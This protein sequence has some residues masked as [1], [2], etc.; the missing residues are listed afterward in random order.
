MLPG[1][2]VCDGPR[3]LVEGSDE[4]FAYESRCRR[5]AVNEFSIMRGSV[6]YSKVS[7]DEVGRE[8]VTD[9]RQSKSVSEALQKDCS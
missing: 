1:E 2:P 6:G 7:Y 8:S 4:N 3:I 5:C 9:L